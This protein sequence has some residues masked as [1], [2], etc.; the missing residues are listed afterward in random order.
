MG[1]NVPQVTFGANGFSG[2]ST[3]QVLTGVIADIQAA[4]NNTLNLSV[5]DLDS[6][7]TSQGQLSTSMTG[8]IVNA[9]NAFLVQSTQTD[10]AYAFGRWQDAIGRI[11]FLERLPSEPT[12]LQIACN[13][14]QNVNIPVNATVIDPSGNIYQATQAGTIPAGG[15]ITLSF[16]CTVPGPVP[17]PQTV[18]T[19]QTIPGWDSA[20]VVTGVIGKNVESRAAFETRRQDS[21]AG[22]SFGPIGA[23]IGAVAQVPGVLDYYGFNNNTAGSVTVNGVTIAAYSIYICV[24]GGA[25]SAVAQAILSKK[26]AG[27]PMTGNTTV[28]AYDSNPLY[29]APIPYTII[30]E[31]PTALQLLFKVVIAS[32]PTVPSDAA[33]QVQSALL[34]A[35]TGNALSASFTGSI[36]GTTLTVTVVESGAIAVGQVISDL[37]GNITAN[38]TVTGLG[39]GSGGT[40][41]YILGTSQN[42]ASE[43]MTAEA[44]PTATAVPKARINSTIY[45][46][47]YVPSIAALGA[48]AQVVS[49]GIGSANTPDAVVVGYIAG[50]TLTVT[51]VTSGA[52]VVGDALFDASGLI[53]VGTYITVF[54][55]GSGG[56]GTYTINNPVTAGAT[57]TGSGS[58][59]NLTASAVTGV[60]A[61]GNIIVGTGVPGGT[62]IVSQTSGTPGGA[63]VYVTSNATTS[64]AA[65]LTANESIT[66]ASAKQTLV[67]VNANQEPQLS[68]PNIL[69]STT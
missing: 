55:S 67:Q 6:L 23:I 7:T 36:A 52:L 22:N 33:S 3:T 48:W 56:T 62:T 4:F 30:Y 69:V 37:T 54:G 1:T 29:V 18:S 10:P 65:T 31:I 5:T 21:V 59:T 19:Y 50:N 40:G 49:V 63:G 46:I 53:P 9:N 47:Q 42:V 13:G 34:A 43:A 51:S 17:V 11:Y 39:S 41:T 38:T 2:P 57:F 12:A 61:V 28:T 44:A 24:A 26:G 64:S 8:S 68:S 15:T 58:G 45:G 16:A 14:A 66:A 20:T 35:F 32:G 27:A 60:I 25:P